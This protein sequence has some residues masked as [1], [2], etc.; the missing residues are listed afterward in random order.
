MRHLWGSKPSPFSIIYAV[1]AGYYDTSSLIVHL[2]FAEL[3]SDQVQHVLVSIDIWPVDNNITLYA[4]SSLRT[5]T[6]WDRQSQRTLAGIC[7]RKLANHDKDLWPSLRN[8]GLY[9]VNLTQ[10]YTITKQNYTL[11]ELIHA[12]AAVCADDPCKKLESLRLV[13]CT[14]LSAKS[15]VKLRAD[16]HTVESS[17][18]MDCQ[19]DEGIWG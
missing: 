2:W 7:H 1:D 17:H 8:L 3:L 10:Q 9:N 6:F 13:D 5:L 14:W 18:D 15:L 16:I 12:L 19:L 11:L 4:F